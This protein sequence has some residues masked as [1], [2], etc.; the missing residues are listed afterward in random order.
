MANFKPYPYQEKV[1]ELILSGQSVILQA[2]TGAGKTAAALLPFLHAQKDLDAG[3]FPRKCIYSVPMRVLANQFVTEYQQYAGKYRRKF[4]REIDVKIQTGDRPGDRQFEADLIFATI[5]Q[6]LSSLL[7]VPY[8]LSGSKSNLNVGAVI[9]SYLVF[10]EYHLF[11]TTYSGGPGALGATLEMLRLLEGTTPFCLMTATFSEKMLD[12]LA[13]LLQANVV[14][15]NE[16]ELAK[17]ETDPGTGRRKERH[18]YVAD[19]AISAQAILEQANSAR[20]IIAICNRVDRAQKLYQ[21]LVAELGED[22]AHLLHARFLKKDRN[23]LEDEALQEFGKDT[24]KYSPGLHVLVATQVVEVGL[25]IS[26]DALHTEVA[27]ANAIIQRAGRC[28]RRPGEKGNVFI[29]D[30]PEDSKRPYLPYNKN[31]CRATLKAFTSC[32]GQVVRFQDEQAIINTVHNESD[33]KLLDSL[34]DRQNETLAAIENAIKFG[35]A[36]ERSWLIRSVDSRTLLVHDEPEQLGNPLACQGFSLFRGSLKGMWE[37]LNL[38]AEAK[39]IDY[40]L[41]YP[42]EIPGEEMG[43]AEPVYHWKPVNDE[44]LLD[45]PLPFAVHPQ[46]VAYDDQLGF[47]FDENGSQFRTDPA[48]ERSKSEREQYTYNLESYAEHISSMAT[49]YHRDLKAHLT[50]VAGQLEEKLNLKPGAIDQ[51]VRLV[52]SL[53]DTGKLDAAWQAWAH[54]YQQAINMPVAGDFMIAHTFSQTED[55]RLKAKKTR[56]KRPPHAGEGA[57]SVMRILNAAAAQWANTRS[58]GQALLKAMFTAIMRHHS[59]RADSF[60]EYNLHPAASVALEEALRAANLSELPVTLQPYGAY[61]VDRIL[62]GVES[63]W[64]DWFLYFVLVR[65][66][67]LADHKSLVE[68]KG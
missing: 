13:K 3:H 64:P 36:A 40:P 2:P 50:Y 1:G 68:Q 54:N 59:A 19:T 62:L 65:N 48:P 25:D 26:C 39:E 17:I 20:R 24:G 49:I 56:P 41:Y 61:Q 67:I 6:T 60:K 18:F 35:D 37:T 38:W 53:H 33:Q 34:R 9:S 51:A 52:I 47:R 32:H 12:E 16:T 30:V 44:S 11:P 58:G 63:D 43:Q 31:L 15:V 66:L 27:P 22:R 4:R 23:R 55:H 46:L 10:D 7:G 45:L 42:T 14:T 28:A 5:D 8:S 21:D 29:Y 57:V